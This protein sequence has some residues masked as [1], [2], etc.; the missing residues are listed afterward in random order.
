MDRDA[1]GLATRGALLRP[2]LLLLLAALL[3]PACRRFR[4]EAPEA[5]PRPIAARGDL[6]AD[7]KAT[8]EL[9]RQSSPSV[10]FITTLA[11]RRTGMFRVAEI[12]SGEGS[13][14][15][16]DAEG[17]VVTNFHVIQGANSAR[18]TLADG[19]VEQGGVRLV[20]SVTR[21]VVAFEKARWRVRAEANGAPVPLADGRIS[22]EMR[23]PMGE[24]RYTLVAAD[25]G[26]Q[27]AE[28]VLP[29]CGSGERT[30][31]AIVDGAVAGRPVSARYRLDLAP[32][33]EKPAG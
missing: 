11:R 24:N 27:E 32:P 19:S 7:E 16:W 12:P 5:A 21:P 18:V 30:W 23:M 13:G 1:D 33:S 29:M 22:F 15:V 9:F 6:A 17:H 31:F 4:S 8:I 28:V 26:W 2:V 25:G 20:L 14:F 10:V 3:A